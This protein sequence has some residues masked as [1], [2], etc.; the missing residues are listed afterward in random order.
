MRLFIAVTVD[1]SLRS[2][3]VAI[4]EQLRPSG[5]PVSWVKPEN[6]HFTLK[7]LG[8]VTEAHL[9]ALREAFRRSAM[10]IKCFVLSLAGLGTFP[11]RGR[12]RVVWIG[13][14]EGAGEMERLRERIDATLAALGFPREARPFQPHLT[15]GRVKGVGRLDRLLEGLRR[16]EV[17]PVG[18]M[19]VRSVELMQSQLHPAG[20]IYTAIETVP[21]AGEP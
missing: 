6:L 4:Q 1:P 16:A 3:L 8:E 18:R 7:F 14:T 11:P 20:A 13:V 19:E 9:P 15:L 2:P 5:A 10:G 12:P 21:L 17:G